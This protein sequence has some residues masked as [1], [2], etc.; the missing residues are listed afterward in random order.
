MGDLDFDSLA[1]E[2]KTIGDIFEQRQA[3]IE[4]KNIEN[5]LVNLS[6][7]SRN[8]FLMQ[9]AF[10]S[11]YALTESIPPERIISALRSQVQR[12]VSFP[13]MKPNYVRMILTTIKDL[14]ENPAL[15]LPAIITYFDSHPKEFPLFVYVTFPS[16]YNFFLTQELDVYAFD[17]LNLILQ[18]DRIEVKY[19]FLRSFFSASHL[20]LKVFWRGFFESIK[21]FKRMKPSSGQLYEALVNSLSS[22]LQYLS[23]THIQ[24][25]MSFMISFRD[26]F[27]ELFFVRF[28]LDQ[29]DAWVSFNPTVSTSK[30]THDDL[31]VVFDFL[32]ESVDGEPFQNL[33]DL[34]G[35][36]V[37]TFCEPIRSHEFSDSSKHLLV[38]SHYES[39]T[40]VNI[41]MSV[42]SVAAKFGK[43]RPTVAQESVDPFY[44]ELFLKDDKPE[45]APYEP[46]LFERR[47]ATAVDH[48]EWAHL[49]NRT[50]RECQNEGLD[51][52]TVLM[53]AG[54]NLAT[55]TLYIKEVKGGLPD[56]G[57]DFREYLYSR[58][59]NETIRLENDFEQFFLR[60]S[61]SQQ[62]D[63]IR[64][65][66][67]YHQT[68]IRPK[69]L[70][71]LHHRS[72][73][74]D[75]KFFREE[76]FRE[77]M[78]IDETNNDYR[79][80][81]S[82]GLAFDDALRNFQVS[83]PHFQEFL[84]RRKEFVAMEQG[85]LERLDELSL[86]GKFFVLTEVFRSVNL[87]CE[88]RREWAHGLLCKVLAGGKYMTLFA[89]LLAV[90]HFAGAHEAVVNSLSD[91]TT[92]ALRELRTFFTAII[93]QDQRFPSATKRAIHDFVR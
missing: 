21:E 1:A 80:L 30:V 46:L 90:F 9:F 24:I 35:Q 20:F 77:E 22:S 5:L 44:V 71:Q 49:M 37:F 76:L 4:E 66:I 75:E 31:N 12:A 63:D 57:Q 62:F 55:D 70:V 23:S 86:G 6:A 42:P 87:L 13:D 56:L 18:L 52:L 41:G 51:L 16:I 15:F 39:V 58:Y 45:K 25:A 64:K 26:Q 38:L 68:I 32:K 7:L 83:D 65:R 74:V 82:Y 40:I 11:K 92:G 47:T 89:T 10:E 53:K 27:I 19:A 67:E 2:Y 78:R 85:A 84:L 28:L 69:L 60:L 54:H 34:F 88:K 91:E 33:L 43:S 73:P 93:D 81:K 36:R 14:Y 61:V 79:Q 72:I 29:F 50:K 3:N 48:G 17:F 8:T 59:F